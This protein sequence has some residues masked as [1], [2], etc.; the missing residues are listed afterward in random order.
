MKV[1]MITANKWLNELFGG[2]AWLQMHTGDPGDDGT[3][4][5]VVADRVFVDFNTPTSGSISSMPANGVVPPSNTTWTHFSLW[6][7]I[8]GGELKWKDTMLTNV[9]VKTGLMIPL[10]AGALVLSIG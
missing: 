9:P 2:G 1:S 8:T 4:Y 6:S 7:A 10:E 5:G 3:D